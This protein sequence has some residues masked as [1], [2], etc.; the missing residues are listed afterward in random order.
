MVIA[1]L[2]LVYSELLPQRQGKVKK[3]AC[4]DC[5]YKWEENLFTSH[6]QGPAKEEIKL[7]GYKSLKFQDYYLQILILF[8]SHKKFFKTS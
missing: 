6:T 4:I 7:E 8:T 1:V 2:T 5:E 3:E